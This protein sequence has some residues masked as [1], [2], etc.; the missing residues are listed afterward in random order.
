M[1]RSSKINVVVGDTV[2]YLS[3]QKLPDGKWSVMGWGDS[4]TVRSIN[5]S[6]KPLLMDFCELLQL[7]KNLEVTDEG[8]EV[9]ANAITDAVETNQ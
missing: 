9:L 6:V 4:V 2:I 1:D 5:I 7:A 3:L 8:T